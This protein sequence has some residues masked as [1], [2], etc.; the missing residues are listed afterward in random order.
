MEKTRQYL[1]FALLAGFLLFLGWVFQPFLL[2]YIILP[3]ATVAWLWLRIFVLSIDQQ[4]YWWLLIVMIT[5]LAGIRLLQRPV[6]SRLD[7]QPE[8]NLTMRHVRGWRT[9]ILFSR[10]DTRERPALNRNLVELVT[11]MYS[12]GRGESTPFEI[13]T[14]LR[15]RQ[16]PLPE[17][18]HRFLF[19]DPRVNPP[20]F[21]EHPIQFIDER[22]R[23]VRRAPAQWIHRWSGREEA[24][25]YQAIDQ[26]LA[27]M[28][29]TLEMTH[30]REPSEA[31]RNS[32]IG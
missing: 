13:E 3:V 5:I 12:T 1:F 22:W 2:D 10:R 16:I 31:R 32:R 19:P 6:A 30:D 7:P 29:T 14:A 17:P 4:V 25:Y 27:L 26:V 21:L 24:E 8:L 9:T 15:D 28:E 11:T 18:I 20:H 23:S